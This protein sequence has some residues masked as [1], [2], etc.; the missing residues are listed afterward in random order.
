MANVQTADVLADFKVAPAR[1]LQFE[2]ADGSRAVSVPALGDHATAHRGKRT[3]D[4]LPVL[5]VTNGD[6]Q[7]GIALSA[8]G[9]AIAADL[10]TLPEIL[11]L[12]GVPATAAPELLKVIKAARA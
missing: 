7:T 4:G 9:A 2:P 12:I 8:V 5:Y 10:I 1:K 3:R 6:T 11:E